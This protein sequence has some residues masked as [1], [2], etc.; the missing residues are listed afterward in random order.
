MN[1]VIDMIMSTSITLRIALAIIYTYTVRYGFV[2]SDE[3]DF[4]IL[5]PKYSESPP[6]PHLIF[7]LI[8]TNS[9]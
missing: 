9:V 2:R 6:H 4:T 8:S 5:T 3:F 7:T 1:V